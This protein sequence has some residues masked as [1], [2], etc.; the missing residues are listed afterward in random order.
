M[1]TWPPRRPPPIIMPG[2]R[3]PGPGASTSPS[4]AARLITLTRP[5]GRGRQP[6]PRHSGQRAARPRPRRRALTSVHKAS[7]TTTARQACLLVVC[8]DAVVQGLHDLTPAAEEPGGCEP[9]TLP[10][11]AGPA[12][13]PSRPKLVLGR[14]EPGPR[15]RSLSVARMVWGKRLEPC[16]SGQINRA[17]PTMTASV[18]NQPHGKSNGKSAETRRVEHRVRP[19]PG[20]PLDGAVGSLETRRNWRES[21]D[22]HD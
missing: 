6:S 2:Q 20:F 3:P 21:P 18:W 11:L 22:A 7:Q 15:W 12:G 13:Y 10:G 1:S 19:A 4:G 8:A 16:D 17:G 9:I 5:D 14:L